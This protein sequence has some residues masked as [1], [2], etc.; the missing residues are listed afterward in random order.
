MLQ[1][2]SNS[3]V[4]SHKSKMRCRYYFQPTDDGG[5]LDDRVIQIGRYQKPHDT[6]YKDIISRAAGKSAK[7]SQDLFAKY[8]ITPAGHIFRHCFPMLDLFVGYRND[9]MHAE[10]R[11]AKYCHQVLIKDVPPATRLKAYMRSWN[12]VTLPLGWGLP[13]NPISH[14]GLMVFAEHGRIVQMNALILL[15]M[16]G[17]GSWLPS[18]ELMADTHRLFFKRGIIARLAQEFVVAV[19]PD[20]VIECLLKITYAVSQVIYLTHKSD[21]SRE[22]LDELST[23]VMQVYL[24]L[25]SS[26]SCETP[27]P[28]FQLYFSIE[29][30]TEQLKTDNFVL[31]ETSTP[32]PFPG[33]EVQ[34]AKL[35]PCSKPTRGPTLPTRPIQLRHAAERCCD[36]GGAEAQDLQA[37][38]SSYQLP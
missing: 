38:C 1:Q 28:N 26:I 17:I 34:A 20:V 25:L 30:Q 15:M 6:L 37:S 21:L 7:I 4:M 33:Y 11:L 31:G 36:D 27:C 35:R 2:N 10:L 24:H 23:I 16:F 5:L 18:T 13:Q 8:S 22:E 19:Q 3:G 12:R 9:P 29:E 14:K 32:I